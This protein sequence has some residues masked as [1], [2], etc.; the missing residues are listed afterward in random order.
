[1]WQRLFLDPVNWRLV[2]VAIILTF[3]LA[4][5]AAHAARV[6]LTR[7]IRGLL[8]GKVTSG[9]AFVRTPLRVVGFAVF[10]LV[11]AVLLFPAFE[12]AGLRPR[13]GL[14]LRSLSTW[15]FDSGL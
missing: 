14:Q 7:A 2:A 4:W 5:A 3:L 13:A 10:G 12:L 8:G 1:M 11:F 15:A 6:L 9:S